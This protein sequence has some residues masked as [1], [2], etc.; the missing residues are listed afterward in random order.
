MLIFGAAWQRGLLPITLDALRQAIALNGAAVDKNLRA[1]D[2]GRWSALFPDDAAALIAPSVVKL[3]QTLNEKIAVRTKHLQAYQGVQLSRRYV[4][5]LERTADPEL[6]LAL[7]KGYHKLL[8]YKDEYEVA[9]LHLGTYAKA[10]ETF[11]GP[12]EM[13]FHLA[14]PLLSK[15]GS[16]GRPQKRSFGPWMLG[17]LRVLSA[18][19]VLRGTALDPFGYTAE[20]RMER[21]LIAQYEEDMAAILPVVTP[22][23]HEIAVA[24]ANLPL[25]IRGFGPVKQANEI[26][27]GKRRKELLAAFHRS[28]GD[29]AQAAE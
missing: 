20:R 10:S 5:M 14:P 1:F 2:I 22:A 23:T 26:K 4:R 8:A 7:A 3:P 28:G 21:A 15:N 24:L 12:F 19:R 18:L 17:P 16:D 9:R 13:T 11:E 27:A 29:L 25:D 6:K